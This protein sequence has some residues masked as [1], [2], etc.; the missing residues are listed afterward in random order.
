MI[1]FWGITN[2]IDSQ[3]YTD[4]LCFTEIGFGLSASGFDGVCCEVS[5][6]MSRM[7]SLLLNVAFITTFEV[8]F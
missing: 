4:S 2:E 3:Y 8:R 7:L 6:D 5:E 1:G